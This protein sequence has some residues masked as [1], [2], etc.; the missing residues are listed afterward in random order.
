LGRRGKLDEALALSGRL[1]EA[2]DLV[3]LLARLAADL[4]ALVLLDL[5]RLDEAEHWCARSA[6]AAARAKNAGHYY[7]MVSNLPQGILA[8]RRGHPDSACATFR[9]LEHMSEALGLRDPSLVPWA[10]EAICAYLACGRDADARRVL[11]RLRPQAE[12]MPGRWPKVVL[13]AG[14]AALA[15]HQGDTETARQRYAE[16]L[17]LQEHM[18][19]PLARAQ[20]LTDYGAFLCRHGDARQARPLL[21]EALRLAERCGAGW[22]AER[23]RVEWRRAGGRTGTTPPGQ[24]TPQEAAVARLAKAGKTNREIAAQLYLTVNTVETHLRHIYQKL[25][26]HRRTQLLTMPDDQAEALARP[27]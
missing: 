1:V 16:A 27:Q 3:P 2:A 11:D 19:I 26:I 13:A 15:E 18:P 10:A 6:A 7:A 21:A 20:V 25:G 22:H 4:R 14:R 9:S 24:L 17:T 8:L 12:I 23:A 5:G